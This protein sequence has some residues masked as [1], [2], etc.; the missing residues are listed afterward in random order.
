M[1]NS[2]ALEILRKLVYDGYRLFECGEAWQTLNTAVLDTTHNKQ[3]TPIEKNHLMMPGICPDCNYYLLS[4]SRP[5]V[6]QCY[7]FESTKL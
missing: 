6:I 2:E 5:G 4:C 1:T 3:S 7:D